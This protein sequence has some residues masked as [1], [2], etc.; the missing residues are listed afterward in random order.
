MRNIRLNADNV[1]V[2][3]QKFLVVEI[4]LYVMSRFLVA[5]PKFA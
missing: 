2:I 1:V 3:F 5:M 4:I